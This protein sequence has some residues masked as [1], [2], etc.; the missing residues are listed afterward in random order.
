VLTL[1]GA[2]KSKP[3][4]TT[5]HA[6][7]TGA[8]HSTTAA[9]PKGCVSTVTR[10][11]FEKTVKALT[12]PG[13]PP[14]PVDMMR[15]FASQ[16]ARLL[17]FSDA[18]RAMGLENDPRVL[19]ILQFAKNQILTETL[20][21]HITDE[22]AHPSDQQIEDYYKQ[23]SKKYLEA[24]LQRIIVPRAVQAP[25]DKPKPTEAEEK[26]YADK[27]RERWAAGENPEKLEKEAVEHV[28]VTTPPAPVNVGKRKP[29]TLPEAQESV[30]NLKTGEVSQVFTDPAS[31]Y[32]Y[33]VV[34]VRTIPLSE[35]KASIVPVLQRQLVTDRIEKIQSSVKVVYNDTYFGP[36]KPAVQ[37]RPRTI[38]RPAPPIPGAGARPAPGTPPPPNPGAP[39]GAS[40]PAPPNAGNAPQQNPPPPPQ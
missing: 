4:T 20:N 28:G 33:K 30:F 17:T 25:A 5:P 15:S 37:A 35:A 36:E 24:D 1:E 9:A 32:I 3:A 2:C 22:Y 26:A 38:G 11:Q 40:N 13:R 23:N 34:S 27:I 12:P 18:A 29:G 7:A 14:M 6:S 19:E 31:L 8:S 16:Y 21:L 10:E 39:Q